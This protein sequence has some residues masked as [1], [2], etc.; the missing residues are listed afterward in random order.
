ML[1]LH[2]ERALVNVVN[3]CGVDINRAVHESY[4]A[5][6]LPYVAG[7]GP[8]KAQSI[9]QRIRSLSGGALVTRSDLIQQRITTTKVFMNCVAFLRIDQDSLPASAAKEEVGPD[10]LDGTRIHN[11]DYRIARKMA[12]DAMELDEEDI[13][14]AH[15]SEVVQ[16]L[17]EDDP[18][19]LDDLS[20][21]DFAAE[22]QTLEQI[23]KR[24]TLYLNARR[25]Q[26]TL[27]GA[28]ERVQAAIGRRHL[29]NA[30]G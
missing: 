28:A 9:L 8:R 21:D 23:R 15:P 30:H 29:L 18:H 2:L 13:D 10:V 19:K 3:T 27:P 1:A 6:L 20:L 17:M 7:L 26:I 4:H 22:L 16:Q 11:E 25:A 14:N 12:A 24:L 5:L